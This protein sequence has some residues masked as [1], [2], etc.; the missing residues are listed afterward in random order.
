[1]QFGVLLLFG[2]LA[3]AV[4]LDL[5]SSAVAAIGTLL[6]VLVLIVY[7]VTFEALSRG[8][9]PGEAAMGLRVVRDDG[10]PIGFRHALARG[11]SGAFLERPGLALF[12]PAVVTSLLNRDNKRV[13]DLLAGTVVIHERVTVSGGAVATMPEPLRDW[14]AGLDLSR[15]T[16]DLALS[17]RQFVARS[18]E[19]RP[20]A[21]ERLGGQ[22]LAAVVGVVG[23]P[24]PG[25]PGWEVLAAVL[26]ERRR[27]E[28]ERLTPAAPTFAPTA[29]PQA[30]SAEPAAESPGGRP[31]AGPGGSAAPG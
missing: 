24:P 28:Y 15:L 17:V 14:A 16:D 22:L 3:A 31:S 4:S 29:P 26:A 23:S 9:T 27:R 8:R 7:P 30:P 2:G 19:L 10:G 1:M 12:V 25:T 5:S 11:L 18:A 6:L 13:G 21:R 20:Q